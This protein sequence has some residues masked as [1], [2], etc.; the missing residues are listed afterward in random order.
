MTVKHWQEKKGNN[1]GVELNLTIQNPTWEQ[2]TGMRETLFN[3]Y[4]QYWIEKE[5]LTFNWWFLFLLLFSIPIVWWI[6]VDRRR[7]FEILTYG[8]LVAAIAT[9]IDTL[10]M[11]MVLFG[12]KSRL[13]PILPPMLP[14]LSI[15]PF[16]YMLMYQIFTKLRSLAI[17]NVVLGI[18]LAF[19][20][21][22]I[23]IWMNIYSLNNWT[24]IQSLLVYLVLGIPTK[25]FMMFLVRKQGEVLERRE[26]TV[27]SG[28]KKWFSRKEK[29]R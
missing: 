18:G 23:L 5:F 4:L 3:T 28:L 27:D 1:Q 8:L 11:S 6:L 19:V 22:P 29:V 20:V 17:A 13:L 24:H 7:M 15:L 10:F 14:Y 21:E 12:Y 26:Y 25:M 2:I 9:F 16:I